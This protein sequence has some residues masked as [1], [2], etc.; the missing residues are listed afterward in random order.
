MPILSFHQKRQLPIIG[1]I[2][3]GVRKEAQSGA[4]YPKTVEYFVLDDAPGVEEVY[5]K[6]P[7]ELE[8]LF[9]S[10]DLDKVM[11][12]WYKLYGKGIQN[13][14]GEIIGGKLLCYGDGAIAYHTERK[15]P[16]TGVVPT[17][18]CLA[19]SC[20]DWGK[21]CKPTMSLLV[22]LPMVSL[23]GFFKIDTSSVVSIQNFINMMYGLKETWGTFK[24]APFVIYREETA[25]TIND[26]KT[27][28]EQKTVQYIMK[29]RPDETFA[30]RH[31]EALQLKM[32]D[33]V[34]GALMLPDTTKDLI[35]APMEDHFPVDK[36]T[37][38]IKQLPP[39]EDKVQKSKAIAEDPDVLPLFSELCTLK[40]ATNTE[41][42][43]LLTARKYE[44]EEDQKGALIK[45]L[46]E[47]IELAKPKDKPPEPEM[48]A[49]G[50]I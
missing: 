9:V 26:K 34:N 4:L 20:P 40:N 30:N 10:D 36:E 49:D 15:D 8:V 21:G 1:K 37:G 39:A 24:N 44:K 41:Q 33:L 16:T 50:L 46:Q 31:G 7:K 48:T 5:G 6:E 3:L 47:Q 14:Q 43:R 19:E 29:I 12:H 23:R 17:R 22:M 28:K 11:P 35:E 42:K 32:K 25:M 2:R 38:E 27:G 45:Y 13:K 18:Q